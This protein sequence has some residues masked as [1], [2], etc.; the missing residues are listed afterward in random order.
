[1]SILADEK[2]VLLIQGITGRQG[3]VVADS[4]KKYCNNLAAGVSPGKGGQSVSGVPVYNTVK[5]ALDE[6]PDINMSLIIVPPKGVM[7]SASEAIEA[8]IPTVVIVTEFVPVHDALR[9]IDFARDNGVR[10]IGP[11]T[12]GIISPGKAKVGGMPVQIYGKGHIGVISRSG[13]LTHE[14]SSNLTFAGFGESTCVGIG[15]DPIIGSDHSDI[16]KLFRD[17]DDTKLVV[18][19]GEIGGSS[20]ELAAEYIKQS[21]YPKPVI[22]YIAGSQAPEGKKMGHAGAIVSGNTGTAKSKREALM[23]AGVMVADAL[24]EVVELVKRVNA[25][26]GGALETVEPLDKPEFT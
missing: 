14:C 22:A 26:L 7:S 1:M 18:M 17:D 4:V 8:R 16:L 5:E 21:Q 20:E 6:H 12:I 24:G 23:S 19:V 9:I 10:I 13:T 11:N 2:T 25:E 3:R 15:G